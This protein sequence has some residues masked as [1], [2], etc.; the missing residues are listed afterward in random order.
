MGPRRTATRIQGRSTAK[1]AAVGSKSKAPT[2]K[3]NKPSKSARVE[4]PTVSPLT[5]PPQP[6]PIVVQSSPPLL[7]SSPGPPPIEPQFEIDISYSLR[8]KD[9]GIITNSK[10]IDR[11]FFLLSSLDDKFK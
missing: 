2:Q 3:A 8:I 7:Q 1:A 9:T 10:L 5:P 11:V 6:F 4:R